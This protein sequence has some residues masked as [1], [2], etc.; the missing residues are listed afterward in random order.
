MKH[1]Y[2]LNLRVHRLRLGLTQTDAAHLLG[3][4]Q[5]R[6]SRIEAG[7]QEPTV[8][9]MCSLCIIYDA[10]ITALYRITAASAAGSIER[11]L[12]TVPKQ[13]LVAADSK[14]RAT[15]LSMLKT[16]L[17]AIGTHGDAA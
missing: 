9:E 16:Q 13:A 11:R 5:P 12:K 2:A 8:K 1:H 10:P 7:I 6:M 4:S 14:R 17:R 3:V 15:S